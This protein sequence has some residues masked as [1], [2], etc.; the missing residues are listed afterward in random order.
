M[1]WLRKTLKLP[2]INEAKVG[3]LEWDQDENCFRIPYQKEGFFFE[4]YARKVVL[5][6][7]V[8]GAGEWITLTILQNM[9]R[10]CYSH[11]YDKMD[12]S[13]LKG[14]RVAILGA[15]SSAFDAAVTAHHYGAK[16]IH[17]FSRRAELVNRHFFIWGKFN[18]FL[19]H[20]SDLSDDYKWRFVSKMFEM[21]HMPD[22]DAVA[23]V[24]SMSNA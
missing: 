10:S 7:G 14:K 19:D 1:L 13:A 5:A 20:F 11:V 2:V 21:G 18:G 4:T 23:K 15:G 17:V 8:Q 16:E 22:P 3:A 12:F 24:R 6:T 9:P